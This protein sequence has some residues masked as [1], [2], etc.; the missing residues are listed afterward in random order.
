MIKE[1]DKT[2]EEVVY[3]RDW[4]GL[5]ARSSHSRRPPEACGQKWR[6]TR[7]LPGRASES[8]VICPGGVTRGTVQRSEPENSR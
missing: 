8:G 2:T 3:K 1:K 4:A 6:R 5:H 7:E